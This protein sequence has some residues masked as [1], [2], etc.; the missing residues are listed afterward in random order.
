MDKV[1]GGELSG[2]EAPP[3]KLEDQEEG[4]VTETAHAHIA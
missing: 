2:A 3:R 4:Y 1:P